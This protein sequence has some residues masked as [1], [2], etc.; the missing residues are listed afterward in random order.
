[1]WQED[2][3]TGKDLLTNLQARQALQIEEQA[4]QAAEARIAELEAQLQALHQ[5]R[6]TTNQT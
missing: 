5:Q 1:V 2:A 3:A 4:R 6:G